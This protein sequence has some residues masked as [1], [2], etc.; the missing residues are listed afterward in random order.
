MSLV[1]PNE[2]QHENERLLD[3]N[4]RLRRELAALRQ[5]ERE[6]ERALSDLAVHL[7]TLLTPIV[8]YLQVIALRRPLARQRAV[9][10]LITEA[11]LPCLAELTCAVN[12]LAEPPFGR[13]QARR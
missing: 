4:R 6:R 2:R 1:I 8:G 7:R 9:D 3:E 10:E 11:V 12:R 13:R 5:H